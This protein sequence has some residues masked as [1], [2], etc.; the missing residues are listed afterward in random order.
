VTQPAK[1]ARRRAPGIPRLATLREYR[2]SATGRAVV[3]S[4]LAIVMGSLFVTSYSLALGDPVPHRIDAALVGDPPGQAPTVDAVER[5]ADGSLVFHAYASVPAALHAID[6]QDV[7]V[8]LD[9]T[10]TRPT[11]YV[12]SAAGASVARVLEQISVVDPMVRVVDTHPLGTHDP[13]GVETF[14]LMLVATIVGFTTV[15]QVRANA[16]GLS[17]RRWAAFVIALTAAAS[18]VFTLVDGPLLHRLDLPVLES[19]AILA[20]QLAA[21][22]SFTSLMVVL[23][24]RWAILPSWLFFV[25]LGNSSSGG[26]VA[27]PLLPL[28]FAFISQWLPSGATVTALRDAVYFPANQHAR[29]IAVLATWAAALFVA[30]LLVSHRLRRS[31]GDHWSADESGVG[32]GQPVTGARPERGG[33]GHTEPT[34]ARRHARQERRDDP[35]RRRQRSL[36]EMVGT[37]RTD[38]ASKARCEEHDA[39]LR[40]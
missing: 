38:A 34:S 25:V 39:D 32:L 13:S 35:R 6:E 2:W 14:Y 11:L 15:F 1:A 23:V 22:A 19:W 27:P 31:P 16:G 12:A 29:P 5:V 17:L 21:V 7:Y 40:Q 8:A 36:S 9:L 33:G 30:M 10:S 26:A 28:P 3:I 24:D 20:L 18:F 37:I 4:F